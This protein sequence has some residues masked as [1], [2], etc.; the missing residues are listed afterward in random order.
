[1][2]LRKSDGWL[3]AKVGSELVMMST[4]KGSYI[5]LSEVGA[6]VWELME[7]TPDFEAICA[8]LDREF[9]VAP[10]VCRAEVKAFVDDLVQQGAVAIEEA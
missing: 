5:G 2:M 7:T 8:Q 9:D 3:T 10:E 1:M 6:R 4:Q